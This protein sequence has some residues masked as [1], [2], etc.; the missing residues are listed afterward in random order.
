[1]ELKQFN[2]FFVYN[3]NFILQ[4]AIL[5]LFILFGFGIY[6][7]IISSFSTLFSFD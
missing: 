2:V 1:M 4:L 7:W 3:V 6:N 5:G